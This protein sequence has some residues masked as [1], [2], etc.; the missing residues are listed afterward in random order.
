M[1]HELGSG[2]NALGRL[3]P[4]KP[5]GRQ[6]HNS[7]IRYR[8]FPTRNHFITRNAYENFVILKLLT[9]KKHKKKKKNLS[10]NIVKSVNF[11]FFRSFWGAFTN[12]YEL[13]VFGG[14][15]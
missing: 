12:L 7:L 4:P 13:P 11:G 9:K 6:V 1:V 3:T 2:D 8:Y 10:S 14:G 5:H 15:R